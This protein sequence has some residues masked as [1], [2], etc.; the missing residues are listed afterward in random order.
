[1]EEQIKLMEQASV[2]QFTDDEYAIRQVK[3]E[4]LREIAGVELP[5]SALDALCDHTKVWVAKVNVDKY[6]GD[7]T[8][9]QI[10]AGLAGKPYEQIERLGNLLMYGGASC[11][12]ECLI[13][14][15]TGTAAQTLTYFNNGNAYLGVGDS[16]TAAAATQTDLQAA[17]NKLRKAMDATYPQHTD[18]TT[19]GAASIVFKSTFGTS[20]A[21]YAWAEWA[22]FNGSSGGR[23][24]QRK[25][26]SLG[27]KTTGSWVLTVTLTL[28]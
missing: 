17:S 26:E 15:G 14:N 5:E 12:W 27:T 9:E 2:Q 18:A 6:E 21:N 4:Y 3:R 22:T 7:W 19:S 20:D 1:M 23:M 16:S 24:L 13:G 28:A 11:L 10:E 25:V 8:A